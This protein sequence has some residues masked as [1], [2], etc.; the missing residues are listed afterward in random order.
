MLLF[1]YGKLKRFRPADIAYS[2]L[3]KCN[4]EWEG[5]KRKHLLLHWCST[6]QLQNTFVWCSR[7]DNNQLCV[8][9]KCSIKILLM[10]QRF[11]P[12]V[13]FFCRSQSWRK[14]CQFNFFF[15]FCIDRVSCTLLVHDSL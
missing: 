10:F 9:V 7:R 13:F 15:K 14:C 3:L 11:S 6:K 8:F 5:R 4:D 1:N 12:E 2:F